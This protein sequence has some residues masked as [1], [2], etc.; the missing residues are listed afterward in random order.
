MKRSDWQYSGNILNGP[1]KF[2]IEADNPDSKT[3]YF[4]VINDE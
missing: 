1:A 4:N 3:C 2:G